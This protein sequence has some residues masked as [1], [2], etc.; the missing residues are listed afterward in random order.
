MKFS[1]LT[2]EQWAELQPYLDTAIL[3]VTGLSGAE[4]PYQ[5]TAALEK[6]RDVLDLIEKPFKGRTVTY[7]ACHYG[8]W[9]KETMRQVVGTCLN[10]KRSAGF[11]YVIVAA[12]FAE[13]AFMKAEEADLFI[14]LDLSGA[15]PSSESVSESIRH[16]WLG[17]TTS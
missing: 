17:Q 8:E 14:G 6:L 2:P 1:D 9:N 4:A 13:P 12:A 16:L 11:K 3:P 5:A 15:L 7:P 10:L